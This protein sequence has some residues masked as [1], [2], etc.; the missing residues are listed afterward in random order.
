M[1]AELVLENVDQNRA[2]WLELKK[3]KV[4]SSNIAAIAGLSDW[5]SRLEVWAEWTGKVPDTF[6]GN[7]Y[8]ELGTLLEPFAA[9]LFAERKNKTVVRANALYANNLY[10]WAVVSPDYFIKDE[11]D[12]ILEIK[13]GNNRQREKW[14]E[15][16]CPKEYVAQLQFQLGVMEKP[17]GTLSAFLGLDTEGDYDHDLVFDPELFALLCEE[18]E[19]FLVAVKTDTPPDAGPG[20][21][22][23]I[24]NMIRRNENA[25]TF[26]GD[27]AAEVAY[28]LAEYN[29]ANAAFKQV[30]EQH[31]DLEDRKK[32]IENKLKLF[33][34][35]FSV[36]ILPDGRSY[37]VKQISVKEAI[38]A[39][40]SYDRMSFPKV[41]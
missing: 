23:L 14:I 17:A 35:T 8:T 28:M 20:D 16:R 25:K 3:N 33:L 24:H 41:A 38:R 11:N 34:G 39:A 5:K 37:S 22:K 6:T 26:E 32:T 19:D 2:K 18:A 40:Y 1:V 10:P 27:E 7:K 31:D 15:G 29:R 13:T 4:S 21:A 12:G 36:G 30:K 9:K